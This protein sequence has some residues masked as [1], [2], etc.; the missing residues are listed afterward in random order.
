MNNEALWETSLLKSVLLD[1]KVIWGEIVAPETVT[2]AVTTGDSTVYV[3]QHFNFGLTNEDADELIKTLPAVAALCGALD[4]PKKF[5]QAMA[6]RAEKAEISENEKRDKLI[7]IID[8]RNADSKGI[9]VENVRRIV[10]QFAVTGKADTGSPEVQG[11]LFSFSIC[12]ESTSLIIYYYVAAILTAKIHTLTE[13]CT[14][15]PRDIHNRRPLR[16]LVQARAKILKYLRRVDVNRYEDCLAKIGVEARAVEG[17]V[18][19]TKAS[20]RALITAP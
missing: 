8:L 11:S 2:E 7:R 10:T 3:P 14:N 12:F 4:G 18:I 16:Q 5:D 20:L 6:D 9:R 19:I 13:H 15:Q 1:R 17:E